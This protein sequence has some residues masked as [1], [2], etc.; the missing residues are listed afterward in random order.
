MLDKQIGTDLIIDSLDCTVR[1]KGSTSK[2]GKLPINYN[3]YW[4]TTA[5]NGFYDEIGAYLKNII[6]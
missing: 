1:W 6:I 3:G 2:P 5:L 4:K